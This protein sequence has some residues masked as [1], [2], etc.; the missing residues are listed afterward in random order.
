MVAALYTPDRD[1]I[2]DV[3]DVIVDGGDV[4]VDG[5]DVI[6]DGGDVIVDGGDVI[7]DGGDVKVHISDLIVHIGD[8]LVHVKVDEDVGDVKSSSKAGGDVTLSS[9]VTSLVTSNSATE[10]FAATLSSEIVIVAGFVTSCFLDCTCSTRRSISGVHGCVH[11]RVARVFKSRGD[12]V[13]VERVVP[14]L[15]CSDVILERVVTS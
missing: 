1:V 7:V 5:G 15:S 14:L 4:I 2:V 3:G 10:I 12:G 11:I 9:M 13:N 8:V 6:V